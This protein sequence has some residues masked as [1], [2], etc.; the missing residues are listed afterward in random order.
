MLKVNAKSKTVSLVMFVFFLN[1]FKVFFTVL[2]IVLNNLE[3]LKYF[4]LHC[5][6]VL[7]YCF[8]VIFNAA[9]TYCI[10]KGS[11]NSVPYACRVF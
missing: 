5:F 4:L 6:A 11:V 2:L 9:F 7:F 8:C 1:S 10:I 3:S